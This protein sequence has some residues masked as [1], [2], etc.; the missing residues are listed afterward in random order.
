M[1]SLPQKVELRRQMRAVRATMA[2]EQRAAASAAIG[3][4]L[5]ALELQRR[6]ARLAV[7]L[8]KRD[9]ASIDAL[10]VDLLRHGAALFAPR[11]DGALP[12]YTLRD[13]DAGVALGAFGVREPV[14][15]AGGV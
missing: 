8:A 6:F 12:F 2:A 1:N 14:E 3:A 4:R 5:Q 10:I 11:T 13:L 7:F 9:E 15:C